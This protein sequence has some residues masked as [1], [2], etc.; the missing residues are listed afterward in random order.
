MYTTISQH[1]T[2]KRQFKY[3]KNQIAASKEFYIRTH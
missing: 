1:V 3:S 2:I